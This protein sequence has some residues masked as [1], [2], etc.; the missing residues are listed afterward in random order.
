MAART[1]SPAM[2]SFLVHVIECDG[3]LDTDPIKVMDATVE[4]CVRKGYVT[5]ER[6]ND[7]PVSARM[8][9]H[10]KADFKWFDRKGP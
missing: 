10:G 9:P 8:T 1:L 2:R 3:W 6:V 7:R 5:A 4:A